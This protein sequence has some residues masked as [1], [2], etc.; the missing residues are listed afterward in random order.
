MDKNAP[1]F[2]LDNDMY[3]DQ[4]SKNLAINVF[5][6]GQWGSYRHFPI[7]VFEPKDVDHSFV[8]TVVRGDLSSLTWLQG[9]LGF[10]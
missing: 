8:N 6:D 10:R 7:D 4:I 1:E 2:S 5:K 9:P 3:K